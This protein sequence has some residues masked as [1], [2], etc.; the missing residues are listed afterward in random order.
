MGGRGWI[1][2]W[3]EGCLMLAFLEPGLAETQE[4]LV[5]IV[6]IVSFVH[7]LSLYTTGFS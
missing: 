1:S 2:M 4:G 7:A 3:V 6:S 5:I